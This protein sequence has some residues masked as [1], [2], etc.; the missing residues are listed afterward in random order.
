MGTAYSKPG[1]TILSPELRR[2]AT[3]AKEARQAR[4]LWRSPP[5]SA[6]GKKE[7][8]RIG[9]MNVAAKLT[10]SKDRK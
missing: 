6:R 2:P 7:A 3:R 8:A 9:G 10:P 4:R 1:A 5:C